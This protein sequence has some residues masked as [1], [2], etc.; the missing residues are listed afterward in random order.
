MRVTPELTIDESA[1]EERFVQSAGPGGQNVNKVATAVELRFDTRRAA[2]P[3]MLYQRLLKLAGRRLSADG[4]LVIQAQRYRS[5][6]RN[7]EDAR[8]RLLE[9]LRAAATA[10]K[11]R[12]ATRPTRA[13]VRR[14][15]EDK[16]QTA[17]R[18]RARQKPG[19][20]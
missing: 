4:V 3:A 13:S 15:L 16:R 18:K 6:A 11:T 14:R 17:E 20:E 2:L 5:Q 8:Q 19:G 9:L 10:P 12:R 1:I 7:R